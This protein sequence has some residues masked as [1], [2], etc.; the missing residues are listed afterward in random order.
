MQDVLAISA[1]QNIVPGTVIQGVIAKIAGQMVI[2]P[3]AVQRV[4]ATKAVYGISLAAAGQCVV[5]RIAFDQSHEMPLWLNGSQE[6]T[7]SLDANRRQDKRGERHV[8]PD[9]Q[10]NGR[11]LWRGL[12]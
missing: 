4:V 2:A 7:E 5:S 11:I 6:Y 3:F 9:F 10:A 8:S 12:F 1:F